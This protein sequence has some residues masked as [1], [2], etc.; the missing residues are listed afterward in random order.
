MLCL[1]TACL[2][3]ASALAGAPGR[4]FISW[5]NF[6]NWERSSAT[7]APAEVLTSPPVRS[8]FAWKEAVL[9]WNATT[10]PGTGLRLE[11]GTPESGTAGTYYVMGLWTSEPGACRRESVPGQR[12]DNAEVQTDTLILR[13][14]AKL[15]QVRVTL[16]GRTDGRSPE[17][18]FIG[19]SLLDPE[20][21]PNPASPVREAWGRE[22]S[23]P[24]RTQVIYPEGISAWCSPTSLSMLLAYWANAVER[25]ELDVPVPTVAKAVHD[26]KWPG[27]GNWPFN[28]AF[29]G[30]FPG[31]RG[32]VDR[33]A[34]VAD[35]ESWLLR[36][37]PVAVSV[38]YNLLRGKPRDRDDG[39]LVVVRGFT[40][41]GDV[42]VNDPGT[43]RG[44]RR[45]FAREDLRKAWAVSHNT[46]YIV[47]PNAWK[48]QE[49][50]R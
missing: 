43:G 50:T 11:L 25:P 47:Y 23:V 32:Y 31:M 44:I 5:E 27:T 38:S 6:A 2:G 21:P 37:V 18:K 41:K 48:A 24:E 35:L 33:L 4:E 12:D 1:V 36:G 46:V 28:T 13:K 49:T 17:L 30:S 22:L 26:P 16:L 42:I 7:E 40:E 39:H 10:P 3:A 34:D 14:P 15:V 29:A 8:G 45:V 19:L 9:S 20:T